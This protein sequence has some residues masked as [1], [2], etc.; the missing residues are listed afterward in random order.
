MEEAE[1]GCDFFGGSVVVDE[2]AL[3]RQKKGAGVSSMRLLWVRSMNRLFAV[4]P[5]R[6]YLCSRCASLPLRST[7]K[8]RWWAAPPA[9]RILL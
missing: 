7:S 9:G 8:R 2:E 1:E 3:R 4:C 5:R 6:C